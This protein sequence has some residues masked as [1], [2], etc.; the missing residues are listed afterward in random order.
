MRR[1]KLHLILSNFF[2]QTNFVVK[3]RCFIS[4][5]ERKVV[6]NFDIIFILFQ[7]YLNLIIYN[8]VTFRHTKK[9]LSNIKIQE[10]KDENKTEEAEYFRLL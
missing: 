8:I 3:N 9:T 10:M 5:L 2:K 1:A 6:D 4:C 7:I